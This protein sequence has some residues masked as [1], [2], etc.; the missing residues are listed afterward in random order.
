VLITMTFYT[1][2]LSLALAGP[3]QISS[4]ENSFVRPRAARPAPV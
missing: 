2:V 4:G 3:L 1:A